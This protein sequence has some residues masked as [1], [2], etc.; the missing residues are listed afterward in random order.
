M[1]LDIKKLIAN[2]G[3]GMLGGLLGAWAGADDTSKAW[4]RYG[5]TI[6]YTVYALCVLRNVLALSV[7]LIFIP[8]IMGYGIPD[9][10]TYANPD[11]GSRLGRFFYNIVFKNLPEQKRHLYS[12]L[13]TRG[14][15]GKMIVASTIIAPIL[16]G[17]W[18]NYAL[19]GFAI[20][21]VLTFISWRN[22]GQFEFC[23][24]QLNWS[25]MITWS[26][27]TYCVIRIIG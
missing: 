24:K 22:L 13:A 6:L 27:C 25:E 20:V 10:I 1:K 4:R 9:P 11:K 19:Y 12:D 15:I 16:N 3:I 8:L 2:T 17:H 23:K 18:A 5:L 14:T 26:V 21:S 7:A